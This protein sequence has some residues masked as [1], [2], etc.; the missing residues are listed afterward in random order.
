MKYLHCKVLDCSIEMADLNNE[1]TL[2]LLKNTGNIRY[3]GGRHT[4]TI[5]TGK[6]KKCS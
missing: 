2:D 5:K 6:K 4:K 1:K 3:C